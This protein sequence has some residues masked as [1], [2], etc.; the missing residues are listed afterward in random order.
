MTYCLALALDEG[1]VFASDS[2]SNAGSDYVTAYG[3][4]HVF[5]VAP[6]RLFVILTAGNL[7]TTQE[8]VNRLRRDALATDDRPGL[9][10]VDYLFEAADLVG[11]VS[12]E[13]QERHERGLQRGGV[14]G[15]A[16]M[17]IG[18]QVK[19]EQPQIFLIYPEGNAISASE[20]TPYLQVGESKYGKPILDRLAERSLSLAD[21]ARLA[22]VSL[23]ATAKSNAT[24][25]M[26]FD[27]TLY[28]NDRYEVAESQR[29]E[30]DSE[31]YRVLN[32]TW[33]LGLQRTFESLAHSLPPSD[34]RLS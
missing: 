2:R 23:D 1:L 18:G 10:T 12:L 28:R 32:E 5:P 29:F 22:L 15:T 34:W 26:P 13:V 8:V 17:I 20:E 19:G 33:N 21:G 6:D 27:V 16:T 7:A 14:N 9:H 4:T 24:V 25:G 30:R 31:S 3:K 11:S